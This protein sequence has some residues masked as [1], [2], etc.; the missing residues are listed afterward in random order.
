MNEN[1]GPPTEF[2]ASQPVGVLKWINCRQPYGEQFGSFTGTRECVTC[3]ERFP[4]FDEDAAWYFRRKQGPG[5]YCNEAKIK[6]CPF[7]ARKN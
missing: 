2:H 4:E 7:C 1:I 6:T 3:G 5:I